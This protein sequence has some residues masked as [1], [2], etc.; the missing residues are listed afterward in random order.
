[1]I[2]FGQLLA[3]APRKLT[4]SVLLLVVVSGLTEGIGL[5]LL[6]P[7]LDLLSGG[8]GSPGWTK[9][10]L[11]GLRHAGLEPSPGGLLIAF[12][13]LVALRS[14]VQY[15]REQ[16]ANRLQH[17]VVDRLGL[18]CF[19]ALLH[20]EWRWLA[21]TRQSDNASLLVSDMARVGV[22]LQS[23]LALVAAVI[24]LAAYLTVAL[25]LSWPLTLVSLASGALVLGL[26]AGQRRKGLGLGQTL[27]EAN[28]V[29]QRAVQESLAG[30]KL[31]KILGSEG[32]HLEQFR[33]ATAQLRAQQLKFAASIG[34]SQAVFQLGGA[35]LLAGYLY[36]GLR[37]WQTPIPVLL[38]LVLIFSRLIPLAMLAH[39]SFHRMLH[40]LPA[41]QQTDLLLAD[42][43]AAA[44]LPPSASGSSLPLRQSVS[45]K[46]VNVVY[47]CRPHA[48]LE[49]VTLN[50]P[51]NTST[52]VVGASGAG[53]STLADVLA[54]LIQPND[55]ELTVD[56][57]TVDASNRRAWRQSVAYV[58]Q[59]V[60]LF[61]DSIRR[62]LLLGRPDASDDDLR[63]ALR[64]ASADFALQLPQ[65]LDTVVGDAGVQLSGG[66]RQRLALARALLRRPS[67]LILDEATSALD[68]DNEARVHSAIDAL[69]G[70]LTLVTI[71]HRLPALEH[72][73]QV[74]VLH[75][76]RV[77]AQGRWAQ[78]RSQV[79][80][81]A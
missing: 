16:L 22:G 49:S 20:A 71:G 15:G 23:G 12:V 79:E 35:G 19:T 78:V 27:T 37:F 21:H 77:Q 18:Q 11:T 61:H 64:C 44:E 47:P 4:L 74:I 13:V 24:T 31:T 81:G 25:A 14:G 40:A 38:T 3:G 53:K 76:G 33:H 32:R 6:V 75:E 7:L 66:E 29:Q 60:F 42:C 36:L 1:M 5:L 2:A 50:F 48:A 54:G 8:Q 52:A 41:L 67:L 55:G 39:Q 62:N 73:D 69:H 34:L 65:G 28:R 70:A 9:P 45:L 10:L 43:Q 58:S 59:D 46:L 68:D 26:L 30:L 63:S 56:G 57:V 51:A 72:A 17:H 80:A